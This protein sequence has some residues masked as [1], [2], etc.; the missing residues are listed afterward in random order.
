MTFVYFAKAMCPSSMY[1]PHGLRRE[2]KSLLNFAIMFA[3]STVPA[4]LCTNLYCHERS[5]KS[6][7][8]QESLSKPCDTFR[9][10]NKFAKLDF[11]RRNW[12]EHVHFILTLSMY[13]VHYVFA[14]STLV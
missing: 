10:I 9:L 12:K 5:R 8:A 13:M 11:S 4:I 6:N 2:Q 3:V 14:R 1:L 7:H